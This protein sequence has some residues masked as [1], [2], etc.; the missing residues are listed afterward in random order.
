M[1]NT[2]VW[3]WKKAMLHQTLI[4]KLMMEQV[5]GFLSF[6]ERIMWSSFFTLKT[7]RPAERHKLASFATSMN[8]LRPKNQLFLVWVPIRSRHINSLHRNTLFLISCL[9]IKNAIFANRG[10]FLKHWGFW[11]EGLP[12]SST[13]KEYVDLSLKAQEVQKHMWAR[14]WILFE[15]SF[16]MSLGTQLAVTA[17]V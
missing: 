11:M 6:E 8:I 10:R 9:W 12:M 1:P 4:S 3:I 5:C 7:I 14:P 13:S 2:L 17:L 16:S 15:K